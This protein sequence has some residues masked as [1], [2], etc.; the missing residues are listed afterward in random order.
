MVGRLA[1]AALCVLAV[2]KI[3][4]KKRRWLQRIPSAGTRLPYIGNLGLLKVRRTRLCP[5]ADSMLD[6]LWPGFAVAAEMQQEHWGHVMAW[7]CCALSACCHEY[8]HA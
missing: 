4:S 1:I 7:R 3:F 5:D 6:L 2:S 8:Q